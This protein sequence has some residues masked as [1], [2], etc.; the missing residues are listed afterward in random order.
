MVC[1]NMELLCSDDKV[2]VAALKF[3]NM[4]KVGNMTI[5]SCAIKGAGRART[6]EVEYDAPHDSNEKHE[7]CNET[8]SYANSILPYLLNAGFFA[9]TKSNHSPHSKN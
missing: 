6:R 3:A 4:S 7:V 8:Y 1:T 2:A 9:G 5:M